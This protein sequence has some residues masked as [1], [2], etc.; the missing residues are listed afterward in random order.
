MARQGKVIHCKWQ[1]SSTAQGRQ[2]DLMTE[3]KVKRE[4]KCM[5]VCNKKCVQCAMY[6]KFSEHEENVRV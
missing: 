3:G 2:D 4:G 1:G 6:Q 5:S